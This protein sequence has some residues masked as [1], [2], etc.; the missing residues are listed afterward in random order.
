MSTDNNYTDDTDDPNT[1]LI[2]SICHESFENSENSENEIFT[3][4]CNHVYHSICIN[5]WLVQGNN[6][7]PICR[8][9]ISQGE[10]GQ[11][12][13]L[14]GQGYDP[15]VID[16]EYGFAFDEHYCVCGPLRCF[17][18]VQQQFRMRKLI[19]LCNIMFGAMLLLWISPDN[20]MDLTF[21]GVLV[22]WV[23]INFTIYLLFISNRSCINCCLHRLNDPILPM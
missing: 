2:C 12:I 5:R 14:V 23:A 3:T 17:R 20:W 10:E 22:V 4:P 6:T 18:N 9:I 21:M 15:A 11:A 19:F 13:P 16:E 7:C 1:P 8:E